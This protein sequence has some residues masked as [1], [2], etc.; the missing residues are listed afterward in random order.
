MFTS[1]IACVTCSNCASYAHQNGR[2]WHDA[3]YPELLDEMGICYD[4]IAPGELTGCMSKYHVILLGDFDAGTIEN[5]DDWVRSGGVLLGFLTQGQDELFGVKGVGRIEQ[6]DD[7]FTISC[8]LRLIE[9]YSLLPFED[10]WTNTL[11]VISPIR[12]LEL[13]EGGDLIG[14]LLPPLSF[15]IDYKESKNIQFLV[16]GV[17]RRK[18]G[19]GWCWYFNFN[20][21]QTLRLF[22]QGRPVDRDWDGDGMYRSADGIVFTSAQNIENPFGDYYLELLRNAFDSAGV[23]SKF[24]YPP[25]DNKLV[26]L[27]YYYGG[28]DECDPTGVQA[29]AVRRM[30]EAGYPY[31]INIM[32]NSER[33]GY[34]L[35]QQ[36]YQEMIE[37][38]QE[39][40]IHFDFFKPRTPISFDEFTEQ[41]D[42]F[43]HTYGATPKV[44]VNHCVMFWGWTDLARWSQARGLIGDN[45]RFPVRLMPDS[46]PINSHGFAFGTS[47]PHF[48]YD[49]AAHGDEKLHFLYIPACL[50]EPRIT[51][52]NRASDY[53]ALEAFLDKAQKNAWFVPMFFHP[54]YIA[55][56]DDAWRALTAA[57]EVARQKD[58]RVLELGVD[59]VANWWFE[60]SDSILRD[61]DENTFM[62]DAV[63]SHGIT[64]RLPVQM[65]N[66]KLTID[67][68]EITIERREIYGRLCVL[69]VIPQGKHYCKIV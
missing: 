32:C 59:A 48:V 25:A 53:E 31:H 68:E 12:N 56:C 44:Y 66:K 26:D 3:Y 18:N 50:Y 16:P 69:A 54:V 15:C 64:L 11:P 39:P 29:I 43:E 8:Y 19:H 2:L 57:H 21:G 17:V 51:L 49:D 46:N 55:K 24:Y 14:T 62:V 1:R 13:A 38:G 36:T 30:H 10:G 4:S 37:Y 33:K 7:E 45:G 23:L 41:L 27:L 22:H 9:D 5:L 61:I 52:K 60:R 67:G 28:D 65:L 47:Y 42:L 20:L 6:T 58:W 40:S 63:S 35:S 34:A